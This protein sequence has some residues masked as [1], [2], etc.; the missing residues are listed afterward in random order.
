MTRE[1]QTG[2]HP[3]EA[4]QWL[5]DGN[6]RFISGRVVERDLP[7]EIRATASA[8]YPF[9]AIVSCVDSRVAPE[10]VF[11]QGLGDIFSVRVAGN[12]VNDDITGSLEFA[13]RLAGAKLILIVG[14]SGCGAIKGACTN[15]EMGHLTGLFRKIEPAVRATQAKGGPWRDPKS[16]EFVNEVARE[17]VR[18]T[19]KTLVESSPILRDQIAAGSLRVVGAFHDLRTGQVEIL[20]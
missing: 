2:M 12:I 14:H 20:E 18:L 4:L 5:K 9:A 15:L 13:T 6:Q 19:V 1:V 3:A 7:E 16:P 10:L 17:N 8:Q 11:D